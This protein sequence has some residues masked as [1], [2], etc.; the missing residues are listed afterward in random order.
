MDE[1]LEQECDIRLIFLRL[2]GL[3]RALGLRCRG[4]QHGNSGWMWS[5]NNF[6]AVDF[7]AGGIDDTAEQSN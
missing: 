6:F 5:D 7:A 4:K 3:P 2:N 1:N